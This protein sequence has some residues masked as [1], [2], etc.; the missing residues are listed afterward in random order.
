MSNFSDEAEW[1]ISRLQAITDDFQELR[2]SEWAEA[3]RYLT[4]ATTPKPGPFSFDDTPY[5]R[6]V[7]DCFDPNSDVQF[8]AVKKGAQVAATV[9]VLEN[10]VGYYIDYVRTSPMLF[11]TADAELAKLRVDTNLVPMIQASGMSHLIQNNDELRA[12]KRGMTD[13][14]I[15][16]AGGGYLLPLGAINANKQRSLSAPVLLRDEVSGWPLTVGRDADPMQLTETRTNAYDLT[17]RILDLSTPNVAATCAISKRFLLGDQRVYHVPCKHCGGHQALRFRGRNDDGTFFGLRWETDGGSVVSGSVRYVCKHC[18]AEMTNEDKV[19]IMGGGEWRPTAKPSRPNFRS[20]HLS[21]LYAPVF[22]R[23]WESIAYAWQE[24]WDDEHNT[25]K[26]AE[27]LQV[28]YNNDL[29]EAFEVKADR[30][31]LH[32]IS[33]HRRNDYHLG[34]VPNAHAVTHTGGPIMLLTMTV[35]VQESWLAVG[36]MA[37][38]PSDDRAGYA[39]YLI[40]YWRLDGSSTER[41]DADV[42]VALA[43][44]IDNLRYKTNDGREL[45]ISVTAVD[46]SYRTDTVYSFCAQWETGVYPLRGR[47]KPIR[48][49]RMKEFDVLESAIGTRY[50]AV[51]VDLYKDRWSAALKRQWNGVDKMPRNFLSVPGNLPDKALN[52]LTVEYVREKRD[53]QSG[54][55]LGTYWHRPGHARQELWDLLVY[56][57][58]CLEVLAHDVCTNELEIDALIWSEFWAVIEDGRYWT[59][60]DGEG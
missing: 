51:T 30:I 36:V 2:P 24:A 52:E 23:S 17:R 34:Q 6:E 59:N 7:V 43:D 49:G 20:Y 50:L 4:R 25:P 28:F 18:S 54:K 26:D 35:D 48:S 27:K 56:N 9:G 16:W 58:A 60:I 15:E 55:L 5:W 39:G 8:V 3:T 47:D 40:D 42:W 32:Q 31:K 21:A 19:L 14:K 41:E 10:I 44:K 29:G 57:T 46:A 33:P 1:V 11:F 53:P 38:S 45:P 13:K 22:A 37:W 12:N